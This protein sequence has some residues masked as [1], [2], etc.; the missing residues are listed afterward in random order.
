[1]SKLIVP[2]NIIGTNQCERNQRRRNNPKP[3]LLVHLAVLLLLSKG[4]LSLSKSA[5]NS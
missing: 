3:L 4:L 2:P 5:S 1:M